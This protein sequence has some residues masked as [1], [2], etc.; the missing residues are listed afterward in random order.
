[1]NCLLVKKVVEIFL[2]F[3]L[4]SD[5]TKFINLDIHIL[6]ILDLHPLEELLQR[7]VDLTFAL[8][9]Q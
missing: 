4:S 6:D 5:I 2:P 8:E 7:L 1:L 9:L 3:D